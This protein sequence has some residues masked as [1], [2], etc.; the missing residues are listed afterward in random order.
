[1]PPLRSAPTISSSNSQR[2]YNQSSGVSPCLLGYYPNPNH[3]ALEDSLP[4]RLQEAS[5]SLLMYLAE[6]LSATA[7]GGTTA[8]AEGEKAHLVHRALNSQSVRCGQT[9]QSWVPKW[10]RGL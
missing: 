8:Y 7:L 10:R 9:G 5:I 4:Y 2:I 6:R 3:K 1:M